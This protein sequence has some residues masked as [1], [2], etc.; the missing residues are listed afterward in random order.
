MPVVSPTATLQ[1]ALEPYPQTTIM[2]LPQPVPP[3][4]YPSQVEPVITAETYPSPE[5]PAEEAPTA[6]PTEEAPTET[7]EGEEPTETPEPAGQEAEETPSEESTPTETDLPYPDDDD[8]YPAPIGSFLNTPY[9]GQPV[10]PTFDPYP[11]GDEP[12]LAPPTLSSP[13]P[14]SETETTPT[15]TAVIVTPT[16]TMRGSITPARPSATSAVSSPTRTPTRTPFLTPTPT[17]TPTPSPTRTPLPVPPWVSVR[18]VASDP[19]TVKLAAGKPQLVMFFAYWSGPSLAM[20]P[21]VRGIESEY[22]GRVN[23]VYLDIDNPATDPFKRALF[24]RVE[25]HFFLLDANGRTL[26][27]WLGYISPEPLRQALDAALR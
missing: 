16:P 15:W 22:A 8:F 2:K 23:F 10:V 27:Q 19:S 6:T 18:L 13:Y 1:P 25:P 7:P 21:M 17:L 12:T 9:P 26:R 5:T 14:E 11:D 24:F 4:T 20:A 3:T